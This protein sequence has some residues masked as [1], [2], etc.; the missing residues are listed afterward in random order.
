MSVDT[1]GRLCT[2]YLKVEDR[3]SAGGTAHAEAVRGSQVVEGAE[4]SLRWLPQGAWLRLGGGRTDHAG[5]GGSSEGLW[6]SPYKY[7]RCCFRVYTEE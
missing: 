3:V 5:P 4:T 1:E 6:S 2:S 7:M